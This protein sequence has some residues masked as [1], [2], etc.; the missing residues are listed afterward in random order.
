ME[1]NKK[2]FDCGDVITKRTKDNKETDEHFL[3]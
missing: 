2:L 1:P 3:E